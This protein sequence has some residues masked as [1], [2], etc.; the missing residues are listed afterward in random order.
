MRPAPSVGRS[1]PQ[2]I[3]RF[4]QSLPARASRS[5]VEA[6]AKKAKEGRTRRCAHNRRI[7][8]NG[9]YR[10]LCVAVRHNPF[11]NSVRVSKLGGHYHPNRES[12]QASSQPYRFGTGPAIWRAARACF[13]KLLAIL[14]A[15]LPKRELTL[16]MAMII[17]CSEGRRKK[18]L[19]PQAFIC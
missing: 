10:F 13:I 9:V 15:T 2:S 4:G 16:P 19:T 18:F 11:I 7:I 1:G 12:C 8:R 14:P 6:K 17:L 3:S 5:F